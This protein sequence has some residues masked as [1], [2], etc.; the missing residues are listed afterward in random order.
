MLTARTGSEE[1]GS[2]SAA[3]MSPQEMKTQGC[4]IPFFSREARNL[5]F[6]MKSLIFKF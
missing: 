1:E 2:H 4:Q 6:H 5:D 3:S